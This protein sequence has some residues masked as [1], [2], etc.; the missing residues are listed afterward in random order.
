MLNYQ[1]VNAMCKYLNMPPH[2]SSW[3][4]RL[5]HRWQ[6]LNYQRFI[7]NWPSTL[8]IKHGNGRFPITETI[9]TD[10][11]FASKGPFIIWAPTCNQ[12]VW[13]ITLYGSEIHVI[14]KII[15]GNLRLQIILLPLKHD[16]NMLVIPPVSPNKAAI[17]ATKGSPP[18]RSWN[19]GVLRQRRLCVSPREGSQGSLRDMFHHSFVGPI[20]LDDNAW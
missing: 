3:L 1:R 8:V 4:L 7:I 10:M 9:C 17:F 20:S 19:T 11:I 16:L 6:L 5:Q 15:Y 12:F 2:A 13:H 14:R 18:C